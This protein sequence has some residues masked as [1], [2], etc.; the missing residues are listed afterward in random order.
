[1]IICLQESEHNIRIHQSKFLMSEPFWGGADY[2]K[3]KLFPKVYRVGIGAD[4]DIELNTYVSFFF[5][6]GK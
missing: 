2:F 1:M 6:E 5:G 4:N 3:A